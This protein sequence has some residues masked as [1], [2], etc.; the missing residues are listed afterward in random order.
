MSF[1]AA[2]ATGDELP[3]AAGKLID[4]PSRT[5]RVPLLDLYDPARVAS[6]ITGRWSVEASN[7]GG[8]FDIVHQCTSIQF[9]GGNVNVFGMNFAMAVG[10]IKP[11][12][13]AIPDGKSW[14]GCKPGELKMFEFILKSKWGSQ[15]GGGQVA[16]VSDDWNTFTVTN[17]GP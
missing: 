1:T 13:A 11:C 15:I 17:I 3:A 14:E 9:S 16:G 5:Y 6:R 10:R 12:E 4:D 2:E 8:E 7:S